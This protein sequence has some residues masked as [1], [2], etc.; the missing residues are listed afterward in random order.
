[1]NLKRV[2][3]SIAKNVDTNGKCCVVEIKIEGGYML[4]EK[5]STEL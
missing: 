4:K 5:F 1:M 2:L 3:L